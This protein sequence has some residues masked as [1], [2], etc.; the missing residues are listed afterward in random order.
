[1]RFGSGPVSRTKRPSGSDRAAAEG[2]SRDAS[3]IGV[4]VGSFLAEQARVLRDLEIS[5]H[6]ALTGE[7][8]AATRLVGGKAEAQGFEGR[9]LRDLAHDFDGAGS[10]GAAPA[11]VQGPRGPAVEGQPCAD[12][13]HAKVRAHRALD[14]T[15]VETKDGHA[16][17]PGL[18][19]SMP[20]PPDSG[21]SSGA[22]RA[23]RAASATAAANPR[24]GTH[25]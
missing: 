2:A 8:Q 11:T 17:S 7:S 10:A 9:G 3:G 21:Q 22:I 5:E 23:A 24:L 20:E 25:R 14:L 6:R 13:N 18:R 4:F 1:M 12:Q 16:A 19:E 15:T